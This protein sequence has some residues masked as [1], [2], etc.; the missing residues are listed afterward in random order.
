MLVASAV[1]LL[2]QLQYK[3]GWEFNVEDF[4]KRH[5]A[6][7]RVEVH[8]PAQQSERNQ[9]PLYGTTVTG[10]ARAAFLLLVDDCDDDTDL[11]NLLLTEVILP[12]EEHEAREF[13]RIEPTGW[14]PFHPHRADGM[15]AWARRT[16]YTLNRDLYFGLG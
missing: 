6:A 9:Y 2:S 3:P 12:I 13:L 10:G 5:E 14:A 8:Y 16:Q 11:Y 1:Q 4:S 15:R 7:V